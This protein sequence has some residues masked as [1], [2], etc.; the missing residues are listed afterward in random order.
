[1][2]GIAVFLA[3]GLAGLAAGS[4][5]LISDYFRQGCH[6]LDR[7]RYDTLDRRDP[8]DVGGGTAGRVATMSVATVLEPA[9]CSRW[10][11]SLRHDRAA[12]SI[13]KDALRSMSSVPGLFGF[14]SDRSTRCRGGTWWLIQCRRP[15]LLPAWAFRF[16]DGVG[17]RDSA[18]FFEEICERH[19]AIRRNPRRTNQIADGSSP[20]GTRRSGCG[21]PVDCDR[22]RALRT[23]HRARCAHGSRRREHYHYGSCT[24]SGRAAYLS[25][26]R[27]ALPLGISFVPTDSSSLRS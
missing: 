16:C 9:P 4:G 5:F 12:G 13:K 6:H 3:I 18:P 27:T 25:L 11:W 24:V 19:C 10:H 2:I 20:A 7:N 1:M 17:N 23:R 21:H 14:R 22:G 15:L 26:G 8:G